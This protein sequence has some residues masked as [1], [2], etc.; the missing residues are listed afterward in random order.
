M[1]RPYRQKYQVGNRSLTFSEWAAK[2]SVRIIT[3][4][5]RFYRAKEVGLDDN[6]AMEVAVLKT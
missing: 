2:T 3:L 6:A 1:K 5:R 4:R